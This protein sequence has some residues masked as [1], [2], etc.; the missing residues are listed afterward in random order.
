MRELSDGDS[1]SHHLLQ[2]MQQVK[3]ECI[4]VERSWCLD[5]QAKVLGASVLCQS[6]KL[7][8][9]RQPCLLGVPSTW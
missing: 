7:M 9:C 8:P 1:E 5:A 3:T 2:E 6:A 4:R